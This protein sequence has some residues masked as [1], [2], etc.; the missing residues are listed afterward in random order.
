MV[1]MA[2]AW[3]DTLASKPVLD[4]WDT[5]LFAFLGLTL[6]STQIQ[7]WSSNLLVFLSMIHQCTIWKQ[8]KKKKK[9][10]LVSDRVE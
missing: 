2:F 8:N 10:F 9:A 7:N 1:H 5:S 4:Q 3:M 6:Q